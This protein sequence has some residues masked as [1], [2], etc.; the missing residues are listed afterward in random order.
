MLEP[1]PTSDVDLWPVPHRSWI[2]RAGSPVARWSGYLLVFAAVVAGQST[3]PGMDT[4]RASLEKRVRRL[5]EGGTDSIRARVVGRSA[6]CPTFPDENVI[7]L[8]WRSVVSTLGRDR[9]IPIERLEPV[10]VHAPRTRPGT[11][12]LPKRH[13]VL[14]LDGPGGPGSIA[15]PIEDLALLGAAAGWS[16]PPGLRDLVR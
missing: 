16:A 8:Q 1:H 3:G 10:T 4:P 7:R 14:D 11:E 5:R 13:W 15:A 9:T 12:Q 2:R 6:W